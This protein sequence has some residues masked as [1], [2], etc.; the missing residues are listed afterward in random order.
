[1][2]HRPHRSRQRR[3]RSDR[4]AC[5]LRPAGPAPDYRSPSSHTDRHSRPT[6]AGDHCPRSQLS[7]PRPQSR[8]LSSP[9]SPRRPTAQRPRA[10]PGPRCSRTRRASRTPSHTVGRTGHLPC[11]AIKFQAFKTR[12]IVSET[13]AYS[14]ALPRTATVSR[15]AHI[16]RRRPR[17]IPRPIDRNTWRENMIPQ[18]VKLGQGVSHR[19][20]PKSRTGTKPTSSVL[21]FGFFAAMSLRSH[22]SQ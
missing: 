14:R 13:A 5:S 16:D 4:P 1:M 7:R 19:L 18:G 11:Q 20:P 10:E 6:V 8:S 22:D 12:S 17:R 9:S 21:L 3:G 2:T 15:A